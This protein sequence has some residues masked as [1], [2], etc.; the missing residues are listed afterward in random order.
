VV[1]VANEMK[2]VAKRAS[3]SSYALDRRST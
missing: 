1:E 2:R 3:G